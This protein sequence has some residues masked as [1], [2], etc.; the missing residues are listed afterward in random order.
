[1][2]ALTVLTNIPFAYL[3]VT[4]YG[5]TTAT[6]AAHTT[7]EVL[8]IAIP[9][10]LL[11]GQSPYHRNSAPV[12]NRFLLES[13]QVQLSTTA[14]AVGVYVLSLFV[15]Q[16]TLW[17]NSFLISHFDDVR[18]LESAHAETYGTLC[19]KL[20]VA[21][22]AARAFLLNPSIGAQTASGIVTP[23][24]PFDPA[25]ATLPA[26]LKKNFWFFS[27]RTRTLL[28]Q[29]AVAVVFTIADS[30][31]RIWSI[32]GTDLVGILGYSGFWALIT[33]VTAGWYAWVGDTEL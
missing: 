27:K 10:Y 19:L 4:Y 2:G 20:F 16:K 18:T 17:L 3:A 31:I 24:E 15:A 30:V 1:V 25:T 8:A 13:T 11:R 12:R 21:G 29:T 7:V 32:E 6:I 22:W 14:L 28:R 5:I 23:V 9:S 33:V 26:T